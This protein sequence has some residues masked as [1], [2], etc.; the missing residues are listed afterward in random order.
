MISSIPI[1]V[2]TYLNRYQGLLLSCRQVYTEFELEALKDVDAF[3]KRLHSTTT[4]MLEV[5][6]FE[7]LAYTVLPQVEVEKYKDGEWGCWY[8]YFDGSSVYIDW[9][10]YD[11][12]VFL[13]SSVVD[14]FSVVQDNLEWNLGLLQ[15]H[16]GRSL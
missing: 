9:S 2:S 4:H 5:P 14:F 6:K 12:E 13:S 11:V 1:A 10:R 8:D 15:V 3:F 7:K 16:A